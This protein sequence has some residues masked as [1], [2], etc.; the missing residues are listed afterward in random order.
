[1]Q[2]YLLADKQPKED[3]KKL[4]NEENAT[5]MKIEVKILN[6][7][8]NSDELKGRNP[9]FRNKVKLFQT[10]AMMSKVFGD[11]GVERSAAR[12]ER[13]ESNLGINVGNNLN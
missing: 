5:P 7:T 13:I 9:N 12:K 11:G 1:M 10:K 3:G 2:C 6:V 4:G 8:E